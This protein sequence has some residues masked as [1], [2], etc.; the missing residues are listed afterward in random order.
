[1]DKIQKI[2]DQFWKD[3]VIHKSFQNDLKY[4]NILC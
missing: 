3:L 2:N 4:L 1:M